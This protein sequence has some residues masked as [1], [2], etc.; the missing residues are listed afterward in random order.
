MSVKVLITRTVPADKGRDML[1]LFREMRSLA[2]SQSGY[3]SGETL[4]SHD[5]PD[6]FLVISTWES[7]AD[8]EA[9]LLSKE[10][11]AIQEKIDALLGGK[12]QYEVFDYRLRA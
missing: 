7:A 9:W 11:Q 8:W 12:T 4:K 1:Q 6:V 3:I 5:R 2:T 10:R